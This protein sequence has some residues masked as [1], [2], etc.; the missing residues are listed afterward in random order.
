M[1]GR[2]SSGADPP[3]D[4]YRRGCL[5]D[6]DLNWEEGTS[7]GKEDKKKE[8]RRKSG[9]KKQVDVDTGVG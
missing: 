9:E 3:V 6:H 5:N 8:E 4:S 1:S 2:Q 7:E